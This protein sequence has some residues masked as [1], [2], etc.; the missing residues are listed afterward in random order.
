MANFVVEFQRTMK[1]GIV[2]HGTLISDPSRPCNV[3][4]QRKPGAVIALID[5][6]STDGCSDG[7]RVQQGNTIKQE[8]YEP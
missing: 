2:I 6:A 8:S 4:G 3:A 7:L 5:G 1:A